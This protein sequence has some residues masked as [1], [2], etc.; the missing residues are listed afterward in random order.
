M[1]DAELI[2]RLRAVL[3]RQPVTEAELRRLTEEGRASALIARAHL[4]K[5]EQRLD[6][7]ASAPATPL[8]QLADALREVHELRPE[9]DELQTLLGQLNGRAREFRQSW[10]SRTEPA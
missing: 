2:G 7:L 8:T 10:V 4:E 5:S 6:E 1:L 9:L 3:D